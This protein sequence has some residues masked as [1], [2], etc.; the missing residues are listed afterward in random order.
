MK[1]KLLINIGGTS[2]SGSTLLGRILANDVK[3]LYLGEIRA[4]FNPTRKHHFAEID[5]IKKGG[6]WNSVYRK[7]R[8]ALPNSIFRSFS[9]VNFLVDSSK[10]SFWIHRSNL[11]AQNQDIVSKNILIY[12]DLDDF[13]HSLLKR[14]REDWINQYINYHKKF[15]SV[16]KT[17]YVVS[18]TSL[19]KNP[20]TLKRLCDWLGIEYKEEKYRYWESEEKGF[21]GSATPNDRK[22]IIYEKKIPEE[23]QKKVYSSMEMN[24]ELSKIFGFLKDNENKIVSSLS[25]ITYSKSQ[26]RILKLRNK[27]KLFYRRLN[28][29]SYFKN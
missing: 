4:L 18:Y 22:S 27:M 28:P 1:E 10:N 17:Y 6:I 26:L 29:E 20:E 14:G 12:K 15:T 9:E 24:K 13:A 3:G 21:F 11:L 2:R 19:M 5:R 25:A 7:G 23:Y 16:V 8:T